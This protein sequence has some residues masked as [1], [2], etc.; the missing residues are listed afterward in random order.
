MDF[1]GVLGDGPGYGFGRCKPLVRYS[2]SSRQDSRK[3]SRGSGGQKPA[4]KPGHYPLLDS[5]WCGGGRD[6]NEL[7]SSVLLNNVCAWTIVLRPTTFIGNLGDKER[8]KPE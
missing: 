1:E 6:S 7:D 8:T 4:G 5:L 3:S 2:T